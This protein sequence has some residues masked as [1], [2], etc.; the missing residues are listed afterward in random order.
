MRLAI[1]QS[2]GTRFD[3]AIHPLLR[4]KASHIESG[5]DAWLASL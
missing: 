3:P 4:E 1:R 5:H 2:P